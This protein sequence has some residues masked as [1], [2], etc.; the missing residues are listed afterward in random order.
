MSSIIFVLRHRVISALWKRIASQNAPKRHKG[1]LPCAVFFY[2]LNRVFGTCRRIPAV[3]T[4]IRWYRLL[5]K[6]YNFCQYFHLTTFQQLKPSE[7]VSHIP[8]NFTIS[9]LC[10]RRARYKYNM[11]RL[12]NFWQIIPKA[13]FQLP[14]LFVSGYAFTHLLAHWKPC[15][16]SAIFSW[17][18][19]EHN[20]LCRKR[21]ALIVY[22][23]KFPVFF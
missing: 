21:P 22:Q 3:F 16:N 8:L 5:I 4:Q 20:V 10:N 23:G 14:P 2:G 11:S 7:Q 19:N 17:Q 12:W 13:F 18:I 15:L 6:Y 1:T 9:C